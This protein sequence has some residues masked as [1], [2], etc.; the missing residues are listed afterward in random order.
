[1][2]IVY[3]TLGEKA[4]RKSSEEIFRSIQTDILLRISLKKIS[5]VIEGHAYYH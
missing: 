2:V 4:L 1:M 5:F 3:S